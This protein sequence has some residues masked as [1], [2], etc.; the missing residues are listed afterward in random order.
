MRG[1]VNGY[2]STLCEKISYELKSHDGTN[3]DN[4][5]SSV[6]EHHAD[7]YIIQIIIFFLF[8]LLTNVIMLNM[9]ISLMGAV[10]EDVASQA[11]SQYR[12]EKAKLMLSL[13]NLILRFKFQRVA[14]PWLH[15]VAPEL[16]EIKRRADA[17]DQKLLEMQQS[18]EQKLLEMQQSTDKKLTQL[19]DLLQGIASTLTDQA[20]RVSND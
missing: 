5:A 16:A 15:I 11:R 17:N 12:M 9:L 8:T 2:K 18:Y 1:K 20:A 3:G 6:F 19:T 14:P 10:Y 4:D 7:L 13:E